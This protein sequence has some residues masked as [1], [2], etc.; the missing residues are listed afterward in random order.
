MIK[1]P[2]FDGTYTG[3]T[4]RSKLIIFYSQ[5]RFD[6]IT[7]GDSLLPLNTQSFCQLFIS[8]KQRAETRGAKHN[9]WNREEATGGHKNLHRNN[10]HN[11]HSFIKY[12]WGEKIEEDEQMNGACA[13]L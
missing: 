3:L 9:I 13:D 2:A 11:F 7:F 8:S 5:G 12:Y 1:I 4:Y 6:Q 10:L